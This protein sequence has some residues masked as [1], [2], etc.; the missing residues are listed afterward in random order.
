V[1]SVSIIIPTYNRQEYVQEAIDSVLAQTY[2]DYEIIVVD[3]G[4]TDGTGEAL[5]ARY[6]S[7]IRYLW[8]ENQGESVA[9]NHGIELAQGEY[10]AFLDSDDLWLPSKLEQQVAYL[11]ASQNVGMLF[12]RAWLIDEHGARYGEDPHVTSRRTPRS[13]TINDLLMQNS[14]SGP[15]TVLIRREALANSGGFDPEI[16]YGEDWDLWLRVVQTAPIHAIEIPL[17]SIRRHRQTQSYYP[18]TSAKIRWVLR[19]HLHFLEKAISGVDPALRKRAVAKQYLE[20]FV[21]EVQVGSKETAQQYLA[22]AQERAPEMLC[23]MDPF[24]RMIV[25][26]MVIVVEIERNSDLHGGKEYLGKV[27][28]Q[29]HDSGAYDARF[30]RTLTAQANA[31]LGFLANQRW[32]RKEARP[33]L[34]DA[35]LHDMQW[36]RNAGLVSTVVKSFFLED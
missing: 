20:A 3:D 36:L 13:L 5:Q 35:V 10:I 1:P 30:A 2:T 7:R 15:S 32:G 19:D 9:R 18:D 24:G 8:Q 21:G 6:G 29:L 25:N 12:A 26:Q 28:E 27:F 22:A 16:K 23:E 34:L 4:S 33:F 17:A 11:E 31:T 14:V